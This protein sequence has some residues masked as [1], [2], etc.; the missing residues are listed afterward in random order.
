MALWERGLMARV[1]KKGRSSGG[2]RFVALHEF[3]QDTPAWRSLKPS[4]RAVYIEV[5]RVYNGTNNGFLAR[6]VRQLS[7][8]ANVNKDT[9]GKCL[10]HLV[11][12]GFL[13]C[14]TPGGYSRKT[15]HAAEWRLTQYRCD[16]TGAVPS[17][18][19]LQWRPKSKT[20]SPESGQSVRKEGTV[21]GL[22]GSNCPNPR[23]SK[24]QLAAVG[25]PLVSDTYTSS[26]RQGAPH[27]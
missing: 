9:A 1:N 19:F 4:D 8:L 18:A 5:A 13:E 11:D 16:R 17:K 23:D 14:A 20:R 21:G 25:R 2:G 22:M 3:M 12:V 6:S 10:I 7:D 15:P 27:G 26:H 24:A